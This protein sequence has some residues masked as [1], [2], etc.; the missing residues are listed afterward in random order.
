LAQAFWPQKSILP[1]AAMFAL[2]LILLT[3][4]NAAPCSNVILEQNESGV[5]NIFYGDVTV[6]GNQIIGDSNS[7]LN[8]SY[9]IAGIGV[10]Q[11]K[12]CEGS[13]NDGS[14]AGA[15]GV[16]CCASFSGDVNCASASS[17]GQY[18]PATED[19][20]A[21]LQAAGR[22]SKEQYSTAL[23]LSGKSR[24]GNFGAAT[25]SI[26]DTEE[27][28]I[29]VSSKSAGNEGECGSLV[30][31][32]RGLVGSI[33]ATIG[34]IKN[35]QVII[36]AGNTLTGPI[37]QLEGIH[38][39]RLQVVDF[40]NNELSG[41]LA[42]MF[43]GG[44]MDNVA[45]LNLSHNILSGPLPADMLQNNGIRSQVEEVDLSHN[46]LSGQIPCEMNN[47]DNVKILDLSNNAFVGSCSDVNGLEIKECVKMLPRCEGSFGSSTTPT[48]ESTTSNSVNP[49][50]MNPFSGA[51]HVQNIF[52]GD[53]VIEGDQIIGAG[54][55]VVTNDHG[56]AGIGVPQLKACE[57]SGNDG[58]GAGA[59]GTVCCFSPAGGVD[60]AG[61]SSGG[62]FLPATQDQLKTLKATGSLSTE[63]YNSAVRIGKA[64]A[65]ALTS[66][67]TQVAKLS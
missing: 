22:L 18:M 44:L 27:W 39:Q 62:Q 51:A 10:E 53:V 59:V 2:A 28:Q 66:T 14:G 48:S 47:F 36:L 64:A 15:V 43:S 1:H 9:G 6:R 29:C 41:G 7:V 3:G 21:A 63:H 26:E 31:P 52:Y 30:L 45:T 35:L 24:S 54:N 20:L 12:S 16:V 60:C 46:Q 4:G 65:L 55:S 40:S 5:F 56:L 67:T 11:L 50:S 49:T 19:Q 8:N 34:K 25:L 38:D 23:K 57:G 61:A 42:Q 33:P 13:G 37:P 58:S 17:G 32:D